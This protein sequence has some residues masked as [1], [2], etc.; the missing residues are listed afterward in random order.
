LKDKAMSNPECV[1]EPSS[2]KLID[3]KE[4]WLFRELFYFFA[5]R[6]LKVKYK[7]AVL[8]VLWVIIQPLLT[9]VIFSLFF[10]RALNVPSNDLPYPVFVFSGLILWNLF[11]FSVSAAS[12][13]MVSNSSIIKK[14]YFPRLIIPISTILATLVDFMISFVVFVFV[15]IYY[16]IHVNILSLCVAWLAAFL[17]TIVSTVGISCWLAALN[18]KYRDFKFIIPFALQ[19][20]LFASPVIYPLSITGTVW[21][22]YVFAVNPMYGAIQLFRLPLS[23]AEWNIGLVMISVISAFLFLVIGIYYFKKTEAYFADIA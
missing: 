17:L 23:N 11:S 2:R 20:G 7:Q 3:W 4:L 14:I 8:G 22:E 10:G 18:V 6:D 12:G 9:V 19:L 5:W 16:G 21:F 1:I 15:M 13:S